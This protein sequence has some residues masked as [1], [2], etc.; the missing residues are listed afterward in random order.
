MHKT[1]KYMTYNKLQTAVYRA[2]DL[3]N[4]SYPISYISYLPHEC[5]GFIKLLLGVFYAFEVFGAA[6]QGGRVR[7]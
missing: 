6:V 5:I 4:I 7:Q 3:R 1:N 2:V